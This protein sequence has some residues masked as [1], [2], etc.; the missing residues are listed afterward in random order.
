[1]E[2]KYIHTDMYGNVK[3]EVSYKIPNGGTFMKLCK[4]LGPS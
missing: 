4:T 1:M 3:V 2:F